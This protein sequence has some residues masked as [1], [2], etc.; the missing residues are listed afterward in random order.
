MSRVFEYRIVAFLI[1]FAPLL[2]SACL[3]GGSR[4]CQQATNTTPSEGGQPCERK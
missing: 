3:G 2:V 1:L 4:Q